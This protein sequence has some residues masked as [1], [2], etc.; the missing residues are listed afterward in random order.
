VAKYLYDPFG[1]TL[2]SSGPLADAN[3]YR[4]SS[5]EYQANSGLVYYLYRFYD[6]NL[7]RWVNR[8]PIQENGGINLYRPCHDAIN[9]IDFFGLV[10]YPADFM[11]PLLPGDKRG[12]IPSAP[13]GVNLDDNINTAEKNSGI[14]NITDP[15][16]AG[17]AALGS[18]TANC[19]W[20]RN[21]VK[22]DGPW[23][24]KHIYGD[25]YGNYGNFSYGA[26]GTAFGIDEN[27][28][29]RMAGA[30]EGADHPESPQ[31]GDPQ[32]LGPIPNPLKSG[33]PP[34]ADKPR[35]QYWIKK[36]ILYYYA[37]HPGALR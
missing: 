10:E 13:P 33:I 36:G 34:Y 9:R 1:F 23:D 19:L 12:R 29:L 3:T 26:T 21:Q 16:G 5:K 37:T 35:D 32:M 4:F 25:V 14:N 22:K 7:Q 31:P 11:G 30:A 15:S 28:L 8:D 24:F 17:Q 6:P 18:I 27:T 2:S 20:F